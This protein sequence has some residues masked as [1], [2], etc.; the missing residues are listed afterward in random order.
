MALTTLK[1]TGQPGRSGGQMFTDFLF[2]K[3]TTVPGSATLV[4]PEVMNYWKNLQQ[5]MGGWMQQG[6]DYSN[7]LSQGANQLG[8]LS[9]WYQGVMQ[10]SNG[11]NG[12]LSQL[13][14][15]QNIFQ[16]LAGQQ[17]QLNQAYGTDM[18][19]L[20]STL[21]S[22]Q[23]TFG[24]LANQM[25][26]YTTNFDDLAQ[27]IQ[28]T[29]TDVLSR[30]NSWD[31]EAFM[32]SFMSR[33]PELQQMAQQSTSQMFGEQ[34]QTATAYAQETARQA[35]ESAAAQFAGSGMFNSG[36]AVNAMTQAGLAP[37]LQTA[38]D[39]AT[40]RQQL[41]S[42]TL[43]NLYG[44]SM[45]GLQ[46]SYN[47]QA[48]ILMQ[49]PSA[50]TQ[51]FGNEQNAL[52]G[53]LEALR[54]AQSAQQAGA[55][56][57]ESQMNARSAQYANQMQGLSSEQSAQLSAQQA[58]KDMISGQGQYLSGQQGLIG[59]QMD[60]NSQLA[61]MMYSLFGQG[62]SSLG[63]AYQPV[64]ATDTIKQGTGAL[65]YAKEILPLLALL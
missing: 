39:L 61:Q 44:N 23:Q 5:Q 53:A 47:K 33:A 24:D 27:R 26:G 34:E 12:L 21:G 45:S 6:Q 18:G 63:S 42:E 16:G 57:V 9:N 25:A 4:N 48:D 32:N 46:S 41:T 40:Q 10:G 28:N 3:D 7:Q 65:D 14:P 49:L 17:G 62:M 11:Q 15:Y 54:S 37:T 30:M 38:A 31:P 50:T 43:N 13:E 64:Y 29:N 20:S 58:L 36:A 8:D 52:L 1:T 59:G 51:L 22:Y 35:M 55:G 60:A 56:T 2:G 19:G